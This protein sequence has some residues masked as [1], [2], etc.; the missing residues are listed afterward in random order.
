MEE[1]IGDLEEKLEELQKSSGI[2]D[3]EVQHCSNFDKK[4]CLL[5][6]RLEKLGGIVDE[7]CAKET[8]VMAEAS[9]SITKNDKI[10]DESFHS[11]HKS[12]IKFTDVSMKATCKFLN[13]FLLFDFKENRGEEHNEK[14][15]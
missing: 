11:G 15:Y 9:F 14:P 5:R 3:F 7:K 6:R 4:T 8:R 13:N 2:K 1:E 10:N 12:N